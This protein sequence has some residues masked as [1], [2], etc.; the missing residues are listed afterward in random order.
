[1]A[2][3]SCS[4]P[5]FKLTGIMAGAGGAA[6]GHMREDIFKMAKNDIECEYR[7]QHYGAPHQ[8]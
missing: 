1:M 4:F 6:L 7:S 8:T 3:S 5:L 2:K